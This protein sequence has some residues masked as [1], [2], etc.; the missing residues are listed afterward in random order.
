MS[1]SC[2]RRWSTTSSTLSGSSSRTISKPGKTFADEGKTEDEARD[3]YR[4]IAERRVRLGLVIGEIAERNKLKITQDEMRRA[5]IEQARRF[6][7]QE[8][9]VYEYYEKTPGA[10]AELRAPI[11]EDKV[12]DFVIDKAKPADKK[13]SRTNCS[14]GG[15]SDRD[16]EPAWVL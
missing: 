12:V 10:L 5:L 13:V 14:K 1:S 4:R 6:P 8:K 11:F 7:G 3:E 15:R 9:K 16:A 2:R